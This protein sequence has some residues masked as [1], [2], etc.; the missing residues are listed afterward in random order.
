MKRFVAGLLIATVLCGPAVAAADLSF[1]PPPEIVD[2]ILAEH[3]IVLRADADLAAAQADARKLDIGPHEPEISGYLGG[4]TVNNQGNFTVWDLSLSRGIRIG[5]KANL[6]KKT[7]EL[8]IQFGENAI[9]DAKHQTALMLLGGWMAWLEAEARATI[10]DAEAQSYANEKDA[11]MRRVARQDA[12]ERDADLATAALA[13]ARAAA[14]ASHGAAAEARAALQRIF[15]ELSLPPGVPAIAAPELPELPL[16]QWFDLIIR[17]S[18]EI[19]LAELEA[20]RQHTLASRAYS[21]RVPDPTIGLRGYSDAA[22][23]ETAL[24]LTLS[25]PLGFSGRSAAADVQSAK[26]RAADADLARV[27][28]EFEQRAQQDVVKSNAGFSAWQDSRRSS[29]AAAI[30]LERTARGY[31]LG[32]FDLAEYLLI[33]RQLHDAER[34]ELAARAAAQ[35]AVLQLQI[36][37]HELWV[38]HEPGE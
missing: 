33:A 14:Q 26:A 29:D 4:R 1:L 5:D 28:R 20:A 15:P 13:R 9:E 35:R 37:G 12:A 30:A 11:V 34:A 8:G 25:I 31:E 32:E 19:R 22:R 24:A 18:H 3:P 23:N 27:K 6:D 10:D 38:L 17:R 36:D 2:K 21:D 7:G 16:S